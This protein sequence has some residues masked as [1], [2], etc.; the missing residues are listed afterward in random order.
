[1][2]LLTPIIVSTLL[3]LGT[4]CYGATPEEETRFIEAVRSAFA[5][6]DKDALQVLSCWDRVTE[7][8]KSLAA[9]D[10][11]YLFGRPIKLIEYR[12][13]E[14]ADSREYTRDGVTYAPNLKI[15]K[16]IQIDFEGDP[17]I[18]AVKVVGE[19]DG[20]MLFV[21]LAPKS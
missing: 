14:P 9:K 1:M 16:R 3:L 19:K 2:R 20:K 6:K 10:S 18:S 13:A 12:P 7:K 8:Y 5:K 11:E 4:V 17:K 15:T 21:I